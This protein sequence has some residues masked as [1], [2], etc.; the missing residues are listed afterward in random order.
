MGLP[1]PTGERNTYSVLARESVLGSKLAPETPATDIQQACG[2]GL[3]AAIQ[4]ANKIALGV[5]DA[6]PVWTTPSKEDAAPAIGLDGAIPLVPV[7]SLIYGALYLFLIALPVFVVRE[8]E[9]L[10]RTVWAFL[11]VWVTAY[12]CFLAWPTVAPRPDEVPGDGFGACG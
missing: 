9:H 2:T 4:V 1:G 3:Q 11:S 10:R 6:G 5:I 12:I 7:W 8:E